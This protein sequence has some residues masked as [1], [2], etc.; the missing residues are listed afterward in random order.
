MASSA[1]KVE[2]P[3]SKGENETEVIDF[4]T[5]VKNGVVVID[6]VSPDEVTSSP[7]Q[8]VDLSPEG[9]AEATT[10]TLPMRRSKRRNLAD[11]FLRIIMEEEEAE[12][13]EGIYKKCYNAIFLFFR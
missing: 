1:E 10:P 11:E 12:I 9:N 2:R 5:P 6:L 8:A 3:T 4:A 13:G 7:T